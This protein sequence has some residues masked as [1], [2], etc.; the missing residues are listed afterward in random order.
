[1]GQ[2]GFLWIAFISNSVPLATLAIPPLDEGAVH[3]LSLLF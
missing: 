3:S 1:M 2:L